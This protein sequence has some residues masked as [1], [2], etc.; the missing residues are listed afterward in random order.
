MPPLFMDMVKMGSTLISSNSLRKIRIR[1][2]VG[3]FFAFPSQGLQSVAI[4]FKATLRIWQKTG[5]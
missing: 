5:F 4:Q 2:N 3:C 1:E